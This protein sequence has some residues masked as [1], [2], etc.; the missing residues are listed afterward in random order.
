MAEIPRRASSI[1]PGT[2]N[3]WTNY[4]VIRLNLHTSEAAAGA[5][6]IEGVSSGH[7]SWEL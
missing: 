6:I 2:G 3:I 7:C 1:N 5:T 4:S